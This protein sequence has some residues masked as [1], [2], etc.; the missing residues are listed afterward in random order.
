MSVDR[1]ST[2]LL[3]GLMNGDFLVFGMTSVA[4]IA[5]AKVIF[6]SWEDWRA[7]QKRDRDTP[8]IPEKAADDE[9]I[10][11]RRAAKRWNE[12]L[13][14]LTAFLNTIGAA[15]F[16]AIV[17]VPLVQLGAPKVSVIQTLIGIGIAFGMHGVAQMI[18]SAWKSEE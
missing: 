14:I 15:S 11:R 17:V 6:Q 4:G 10:R 7:R 2:E 5:A 8:L 3:L 18:L 16:L 1:T 12:R 13:K 9:G